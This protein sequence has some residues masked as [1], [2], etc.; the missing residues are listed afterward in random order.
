MLMCTVAT[1]AACADPGESAAMAF[2]SLTVPIVWSR[3]AVRGCGD[4]GAGSTSDGGGLTYLE[5]SWMSQ[6]TRTPDGYAGRIIVRIS[7]ARIDLTAFSWRR[8]TR[9][10]GDVLRTVYRATLWHELGHVRTALASVAAINAE[11][12][13]TASSPDEYLALARQRGNAALARIGEEQTAYDR[14]VD[15]GLRQDAVPGPLAGPDTFVS[16]PAR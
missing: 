10:E 15:H 13:F 6:E 4:I 8:M 1:F 11:D 16:C 12:G 9:A 7:A 5:T 3:N 14:A 2:G